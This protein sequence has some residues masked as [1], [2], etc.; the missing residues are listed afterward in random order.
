MSD[1]SFFSYRGSWS[2][3]GFDT[4]YN[5][6]WRIIGELGTI[7]WD[8]NLDVQLERKVNNRNLKEKIHIPF[9]F[10][11][12]EVF[13]YELE[14]NIRLFINSISTKTLPDCWC[15]DNL[16]T[17]NMVLSAIKSSELNKPIRIKSF[18]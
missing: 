8:G 12:Y 7:I 6:Q 3:W 2:S 10:T 18:S 13:L 14:Q 1:K 11:P 15:G 16:N 17:L 4:S 5:G 9:T